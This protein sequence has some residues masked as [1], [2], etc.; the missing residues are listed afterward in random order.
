[1]SATM[2]I[3]Q[4]QKDESALTKELDVIHAVAAIEAHV[5]PLDA[6]DK[7]AITDLLS[8]D[9]NKLLIAKRENEAV[10]GYCLYQQLFEQGEI[11][12]I[13]THPDHQRQGI[14]AQLLER[15]FEL[16]NGQG[17][18]SLLL[19]V[20]ADNGPAIALYERYGFRVIHVRKD[21]YQAANQASMDALIMSCDLKR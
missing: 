21:Y 9:M 10:V 13:A 2:H 12:R 11:F 1:M 7:Q 15:L 14:A 3:Q 16:L 6:W 18:E 19:E 4:Y 5:Q 8:Q 20:R 17:V